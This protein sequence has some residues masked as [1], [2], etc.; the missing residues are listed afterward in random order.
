MDWLACSSW[1]AIPT[2]KGGGF[3]RIKVDDPSRVQKDL[4]TRQRYRPLL[5][6]NLVQV[7]NIMASQYGKLA[8]VVVEINDRVAV[9]LLCSDLSSGIKKNQGFSRPTRKTHKEF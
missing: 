6:C 7:R 4:L 3:A 5:F 1:A 2:N 9:M 8:A